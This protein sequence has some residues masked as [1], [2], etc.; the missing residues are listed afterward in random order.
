MLLTLKGVSFDEQER[1]I[2]NLI[3]AT[4]HP[5]SSL[6][7]P[8]PRGEGQGVR[9]VAVR[10]CCIDQSGIG[11]MLAER[12]VQ[13]YGAVVEPVTFT[14]QLKERLAPMVKQAFEERTVRIPDN[15]EVRADINSVKRFV[16]PAGN[17]RFDAEHTDRGHADRFWALAQV[18]NAASEPQAHFDEVAGLVGSPVMAGFAEMIL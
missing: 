5:S 13:K 12:L 18:I 1:A 2:C 6:G 7:H 4:P 8:L 10:R 11:M 16:T 14:A 9:G 3:E 15:R 17:V